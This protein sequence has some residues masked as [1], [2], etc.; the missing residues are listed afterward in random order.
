[1]TEYFCSGE[2]SRE[3][4]R[5]QQGEVGLGLA[6]QS[7]GRWSSYVMSRE[8]KG[9]LQV[10]GEPMLDRVMVGRRKGEAAPHCWDG[11]G[12]TGQ[13]GWREVRGIQLLSGREE[14]G[15]SSCCAHVGCR[16]AREALILN[17]CEGNRPP[18]ESSPQ[19]HGEECCARWWQ[20]G[21][22]C[23]EHSGRH[24][25]HYSSEELSYGGGSGNEHFQQG[26]AGCRLRWKTLSQSCVQNS[27]A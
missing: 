21:R 4:M 8:R 16:K 2:G 6:A 22:H 11:W 13:A 10:S 19:S 15:G 25:R 3:K 7:G 20:S 5:G 23:P 9:T 24:W 27:N 1:M 12:T 26:K 18:V 17:H 14:G